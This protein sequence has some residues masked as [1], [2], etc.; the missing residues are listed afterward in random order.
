MIG[1][2]RC[3]L[4]VAGLI[5]RSIFRSGGAACAPALKSV[6]K[7]VSSANGLD[8]SGY[9]MARLPR[10]SASALDEA[11]ARA[12]R[13]D[14]RQAH[15]I[16]RT[17]LCELRRDACGSG[18]S[19][20]QLRGAQQLLSRGELSLMGACRIPSESLPVADFSGCDRCF[21]ALKFNRLR[22]WTISPAVRSRADSREPR[23]SGHPTSRGSRVRSDIQGGHVIQSGEWG[24]RDVLPVWVER[25]GQIG[26]DA[27]PASG[28][29][30]WAA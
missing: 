23:P 6:E 15:A 21:Q 11:H 13:H 4:T 9:R 2:D 12:T 20:C 27:G 10:R 24:E 26:V 25:H 1:E 14:R 5:A 7:R 18:A 30:E 29:S 3:A 28:S 22:R 16:D 19:G 8:R 17:N